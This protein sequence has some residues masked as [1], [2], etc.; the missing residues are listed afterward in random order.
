MSRTHFARGVAFAVAVAATVAPSIVGGQQRIASGVGPNGMAWQAESRMVGVT[1]TAQLAAGGNPAYFANTPAYS[2][3]VAIISTYGPANPG[4]PNRNFICTGSLLSDRLTVLTAAHC[5]TNTVLGVPLTAPIATTV[6][7]PNQAFSDSN[8]VNTV[9]GSIAAIP[10]AST[11][12]NPLYSGDVI[13]QNDIA[14]VK[15]SAPA[16]A[17]ALSYS[18]YSPPGG[19]LTGAD[20]NMAGYGGRSNGGGNVGQNLG[21]GLLRQTNNRFDY[22][23]G[24]SDFGGQWATILGEPA[25]QIAFS[26]VSDFDNGLAA[27]DTACRVAAAINATLTSP[28][29]CNLGRGA[30]EGSVAG[31]DSGGPQFINGQ[32]ASV[33]SYGLTFGT[34][35]GDILSGLNSSFGEFNG[36][37]PTFI[38]TN[39]I[40]AQLSVNVVPEPATFGLMAFGLVVVGAAAR[41]RRAA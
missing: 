39:W 6:Y 27:N 14:V 19:D 25:A 18:L 9:N 23:L 16:P 36:F 41:R 33:T 30:S 34:G 5:V 2:G 31:G 35:F 1:S 40:N 10:G 11:A 21:T 38:H 37:V 26:Y 15:L 24:D 17:S 29:F 4:G 20:F 28:K 32:I 12:Y 7:F 3:V 22:R 13:D 8:V